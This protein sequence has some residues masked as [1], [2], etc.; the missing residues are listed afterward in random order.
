MKRAIFLVPLLLSLIISL[1]VAGSNGY[2]SAIAPGPLGNVTISWRV[3]ESSE[4]PFSL[5]WSG[6]G[7]WIAS[8][9]SEMLFTVTSI[10]DD[11]VGQIT[12]GNHSWAANDTDIAND[13]V[14]GVAGFTPFLPGFVVKNS[15]EDI[16]ELTTIAEES[17]QRV[18]GNYLNGTMEIYYLNL[19]I[20]G[21]MSNWVAFNYTQDPT[22]FGEPQKTFLAYDTATGILMQANTSYSFGVPYSLVLEFVSI[23]APSGLVPIALGSAGIGIIIIVGVSLLRKRRKDRG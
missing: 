17:A 11:V 18:Y 23:S 1:P 20:N 9:D 3:I 2:S 16:D 10:G 13:L 21:R 5:Y 4:V 15:A 7:K 14:L 8:A 19:E 12:L 22:G 6:T